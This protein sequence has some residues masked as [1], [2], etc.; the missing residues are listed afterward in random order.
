MY[1]KYRAHQLK[2]RSI[3][4]PQNLQIRNVMDLEERHCKTP[5]SD[6]H[7][8]DPVELSSDSSI[9][10]DVDLQSFV[11]HESNGGSPTFDDVATNSEQHAKNTGEGSKPALIKIGKHDIVAHSRMRVREEANEHFV[12]KRYSFSEGDEIPKRKRA[13]SL[14]DYDLAAYSNMRVKDEEDVRYVNQNKY[15]NSISEGRKL[16]LPEEYDVVAYSSLRV[17]EEDNTSER[18]SNKYRQSFDAGRNI[19]GQLEPLKEYDIVAYSNMRVRD[20]DNLKECNTN[21]INGDKN[22]KLEGSS[23]VN[24]GMEQVCCDLAKSAITGAME[25]IRRHMP[26]KINKY[27][28]N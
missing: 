2:V 14:Q 11:N 8:D 20:E 22:G 28:A 6:I 26:V 18:K 12:S 9:G 13:T 1:A 27:V 10:G 17:R 24:K 21:K 4:E 5:D 23:M 3:S 25:E 16:A 19:A 7:N 15:R